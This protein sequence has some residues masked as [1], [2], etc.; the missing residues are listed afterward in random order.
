MRPSS[1]LATARVGGATSVGTGACKGCSPPAAHG[2]TGLIGAH[3]HYSRARP[4]AHHLGAQL[5]LVHARDATP[6]HPRP[7]GRA[8]PGGGVRPRGSRAILRQASP[9][10]PTPPPPGPTQRG[11]A[12][13]AVAQP[14]PDERRR[15]PA[16][17]PARGGRARTR[18][19][20][21]RRAISAGRGVGP[22]V[23]PHAGVARAPRRAA[24]R[25][26]GSPR[27]V[28]C[29]GTPA[30]PPRAGRAAA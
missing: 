12:H 25:H 2:G 17:R 20:C 21:D 30:R 8:I 4:P 6:I 22:G 14:R 7:T 1:G 26:A 29:Q 3:P 19:R 16:R 10:P 11:R 5:C 15:G 24:G 28:V 18:D 23:R 9:P 13:P 27:A